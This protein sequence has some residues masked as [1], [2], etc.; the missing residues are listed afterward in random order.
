MERSKKLVVSRIRGTV[1]LLVGVGQPMVEKWKKGE[2][3]V[4]TVGWVPAKAYN[5]H[6][7]GWQMAVLLEL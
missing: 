5:C 1:E 6:N 7:L 2:Q 3:V 4:R